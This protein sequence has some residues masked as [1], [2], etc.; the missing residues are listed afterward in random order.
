[1]RRSRVL[2]ATCLGWSFYVS[3]CFANGTVNFQ[4]QVLPLINQ[5]PFFAQF[6]SQTFVFEKDAVG[7]TVGT[8]VSRKLGLTR[9]GPYR[10][11]ARLRGST[12]SD[13]CSL[14]V[15]IDTDT[16]FL[17]KNGNEID[18]PE[19]AES[20]KE[21]FYAI[22]VNPPPGQAQVTDAQSITGGNHD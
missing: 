15:V 11:C 9:I 18:G 8:N 17:D 1:M 16:H 3:N 21:D 6:L 22:E 7:A 13:S 10:V 2:W 14:Q 5:R 19:G 12:G 20:V 4:E